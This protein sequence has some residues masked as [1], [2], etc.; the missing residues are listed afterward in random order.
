MRGSLAWLKFRL[1]RFLSKVTAKDS[2]YRTD[3]SYGSTALLGF[4]TEISMDV[5]GI[6]RSSM[7]V[8]TDVHGSFRGR[9][10]PP[11]KL[12]RSSV[13]VVEVRGTPWA[14]TRTFMEQTS[15]EVSVE[16]LSQ[17]PGKPL[18]KVPRRLPW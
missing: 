10:G 18:R 1:V 5:H 17:L 3:H 8:S 4:S 11:R 16:I 13:E 6:P 2:F 15:A 7:D 9:F 14:S 12:H